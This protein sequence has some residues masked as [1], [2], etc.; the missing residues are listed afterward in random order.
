MKTQIYPQLQKIF[1]TLALTAVLATVGLASPA[2]HA[3]TA[4]NSRT[5]AANGTATRTK[6]TSTTSSETVS[7]E[8]AQDANVE[9]IKQRYWTGGDDSDL[10][11]VQNR[12]YTKGNRLELGVFGGLISS[13]PFLSV[14]TLGGSIGYHLSEYW[15][16]HIVGWKS[17]VSSSSD[18]RIFDAT[19]GASVN[20][21][22]PKSFVDGEVAYSLIYG[23]LSLV[24]KSILYYDLRLIAGV[25]AT[26]TENGTYIGPV[27]G[28]GQQIY[29]TRSLALK[30]D[31]R[32]TP[33]HEDIVEKE[34]PATRGQVVDNR[35]NWSHALTLGLS[36][37]L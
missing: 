29:L 7:G 23:K 27:V 25:G 24:G 10:G 13:D 21:N 31:Y 9:G 35:L 15:G 36:I 37:L 11:V 14:R 16:L 5:Y 17:F 18:L 6:T 26:T 8:G 12:L 33:Y 4:R 20:T 22:E 2:A 30:A 32:L 1:S 34:I 19:R 3:R 28:I